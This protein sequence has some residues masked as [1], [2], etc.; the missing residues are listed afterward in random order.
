[1]ALIVISDRLAPPA[2][3]E[4]LTYAVDTQ[5]EIRLPGQLMQQATTGSFRYTVL[6]NQPAGHQIAELVTVALTTQSAPNSF[7]ELL[8]DISRANSPLQVETDAR[9]QL[10]HVVNKP[11]LAV[12]WRELLPWLLT[13]HRQLPAAAA[14]LSQVA[15]QYADDND[16]L[17]Q[18]VAHKGTC[19]V[20]LPGLYGLRPAGGD[21]RTDQKTLHQFFS[22]GSLPLL[23]E[24]TTA[25]TDIFDQTAQVQGTG[26]LDAARF[27]HGAFQQHLSAMTGPVARPP[28]LQIAW[29]EQYTVSR[30][31][32]GIVAGE[33]TLRVG[34]PGVYEQHTRHTLRQT[35]TPA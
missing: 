25:A 4:S 15:L 8:L 35:S 31:G 34:I 29:A 6:A 10:M 24:W 28:A 16:R 30:T 13:K 17:E 14:L 9:G 20:V 5:M 27:D 7:A 11:A 32:R 3:A 19:G 2:P 22:G 12:Q 18:A 23:V 26:R 33:Q 21:T 1:M